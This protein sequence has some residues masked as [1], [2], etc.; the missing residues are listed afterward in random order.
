MSPEQALG[1]PLDPRS[2]LF[3]F[4]IM[5]YEMCTGQSP[6]SGDTTG[7]LLISIVQQVPV[8]PAQLNPDVPEELAAS[9]TDAWKK[10]RNSA[11]STHR[12]FAPI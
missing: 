8:T 11:I 10:T 6:F 3:S 2:D 4:G 1:K 5:L 7:E 12:R 9:S